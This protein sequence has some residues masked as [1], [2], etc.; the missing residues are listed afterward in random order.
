MEARAA[1]GQHEIQEVNHEGKK[2]AEDGQ[3]EDI[4]KLR[5]HE[6][7]DGGGKADG[8]DSDVADD[9][10]DVTKEELAL[11]GDNTYIYIS[12]RLIF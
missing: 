10:A 2:D 11:Y 12:V 4:E 7:Q 5:G 9:I 3:S 8:R 1:D 6:G